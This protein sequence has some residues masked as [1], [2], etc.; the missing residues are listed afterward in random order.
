MRVLGSYRVFVLKNGEGLWF[1]VVFMMLYEFLYGVIGEGR[2]VFLF[3]F[4]GCCL[5]F[6]IILLGEGRVFFKILEF[7]LLVFLNKEVM[8]GNRND[9]CFY[10][11]GG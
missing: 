5:W 2:W 8:W 3:S 10:L 11:Y 4:F 7:L 6:E 9:Y 1:M